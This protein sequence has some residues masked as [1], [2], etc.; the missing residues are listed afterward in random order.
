[1]IG[2]LEICVASQTSGN[3]PST[4]T[5]TRTS[6]AVSD[7]NTTQGTVGGGRRIDD[8]CD[9]N[10]EWPSTEH[11]CSL[12]CGRGVCRSL[13]DGTASCACDTNASGPNCLRVCCKRC[14]EFGMCV[15]DVTYQE[16][17]MCH[18]LFRGEFCDIYDPVNACDTV[19]QPPPLSLRDCGYGHTCVNG[20]CANGTDGGLYCECVPGA[21]GRLCG[22]VCC[23]NCGIHG[24][25]GIHPQTGNEVCLCKTGYT[26]K[27][28]DKL[29]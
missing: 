6:D 10:Y 15:R 24:A 22:E 29:G 12:F 19:Y 11:E 27:L 28:C 13:G 2:T 9:P 16:L 1:M 21:R 3:T 18:P 5:P 4:N 7:S 26:G 25:C 17:C 23:L 14:G 8:V 20:I